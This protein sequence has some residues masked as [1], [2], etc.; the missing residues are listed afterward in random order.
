MK[1]GIMQPYF[2]PYWGYFDLIWRCDEWVVFDTAQYIRHGWVNRNRILHP[3][4]SWQY[5]IVPLQKHARETAI[6]DIKMMEGQE[7]RTRICG[8]LQHYR[9][10]APYYHEVAHLVEDVLSAPVKTL[11]QLN[12][13]CLQR[14]C[15]HLEIP[16]RFQIF[17]EMKL[18]MP[19]IFEPGH[20][21]LEISSALGA[22][23]YL[24]PPGGRALF[25]ADDFRAR[26]ITLTIQEPKPFFY[27]TPGYEFVRDLSIIDVMMWNSPKQIRA[28]FEASGP[29][30]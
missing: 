3:N 7:W 18:P 9:G 2:A 27:A 16:F 25:N 6:M 24:N 17:S 26:G 21:A 10:K 30:A 22:S 19:A 12:V 28:H 5:L 20:W 23:E 4:T 11:S 1:L 14:C 8:Q 13:Y 15:A 29:C